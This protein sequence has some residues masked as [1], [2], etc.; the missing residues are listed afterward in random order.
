MF[1]NP[2]ETTIKASMAQ[3][4]ARRSHILSVIT[5]AI[6]RSRVRPP[7]RAILFAALRST[8]LFFGGTTYIL[9]SWR[10][11]YRSRKRQNEDEF[12]HMDHAHNLELPQSV[13]ARSIHY[14]IYMLLVLLSV[15]AC[16]WAS[17]LYSMPRHPCIQFSGLQASPDEKVRLRVCRTLLLSPS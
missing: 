5:R 7:L 9:R 11:V 15:C 8:I 13:T 3:L 1:C 16:A 12:L 14:S 6:L 2:G 17:D 4:V 10:M